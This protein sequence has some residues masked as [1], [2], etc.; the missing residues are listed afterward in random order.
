MTKGAVGGDSRSMERLRFHYEIEK[1]LAT[2]LR[3]AS[4]EDRRLL[5]S[6]VYNEMFQRVPDHP[7]LTAVATA[8]DAID[9]AT[10]RLQLLAPFLSKEVTFLEVG[11]GDCAVS[12]A[13]AEQVKQVYAVDV[14]E[15][16]AKVAT[17]PSNFR[18]II[19]DGS[20]IPVPQ[21]TVDLS[22]SDQLMEH[23]HPEDALDQLQNIYK[24]LSSNG[25][26]ICITPNKLFGPT[27]VSS[28]FDAVATC[29][30][31]KEYTVSELNSMFK[32]AGFRKTRI[33]LGGR[34]IF[35]KIPTLPMLICEK[36][37][38]LFSQKFRRAHAYSIPFRQFRSIRLVG[39]K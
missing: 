39:Y 4:K 15:E 19:S 9:R 18:L 37:L 1:E 23:L 3:T 38:G 17:P 31:L 35:I 28:F 36:L 29:F 33:I 10:P 6:S 30:H 12:L 2:K 34:G 7:M 22:F 20:S 8:K 5:Y 21:G 26:Y 13:V 11:P 27:D 32:A 14:S 16:I 24:S 25:I